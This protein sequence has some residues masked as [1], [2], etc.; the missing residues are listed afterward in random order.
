[1]FSLFLSVVVSINLGFVDISVKTT[2]K[3]LI[4]NFLAWKSLNSV[5]KKQRNL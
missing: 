3:I 4:N 2:S 5:G 1:M